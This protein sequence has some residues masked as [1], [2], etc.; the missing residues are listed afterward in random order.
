MLCKAHAA[1]GYRG[2]I[3]IFAFLRVFANFYKLIFLHFQD[4]TKI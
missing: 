2:E 1:G 3:G 4:F